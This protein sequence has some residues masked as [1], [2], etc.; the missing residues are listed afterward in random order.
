MTAGGPSVSRMKIHC[1]PCAQGPGAWAHAYGVLKALHEA[2]QPRLHTWVESPEEADVILLCNPIQ[3]QGDTS[4]AHPLRRRFPNKTF[5]LHDDWKTPIRY[6]GIYANAPRGAFWKGRFRTASYALHHP[7]FKN[8]YV[9]AFQPAQALPPERRDILFSFA[10]RNCHPVRERLFQ[11]RFNRPDIL[12]RD[13]SSFDAF[14]HAADGKDPAQREYFELSLRCKYILCPRGVGPNSI[15][16]FEALQLGIAPIILADAWIPPEGPDWEKFA[17]FVKES[18]VDR[19]EEIA[20]AHEGEF[21]ERGREALRAHEA[22]FAPH[23]YFNYL[24]AAA[25]SIRRHRIIPEAVMQ[26]SVRLGHGLRKVAR[27][28]SGGAA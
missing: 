3:K 1:Q 21:I 10:G 20:T 6:P 27:K 23:A 13:T 26:A 2:S 25:D 17:L 28:L 16:L 19:I 22:F 9:Q 7:D 5:I 14:K 18:D 11:L 8:P 15:R 4:G 24:V 12:V